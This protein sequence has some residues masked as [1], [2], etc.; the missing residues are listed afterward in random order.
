M[1]IDRYAV[2]LAAVFVLG[3][4]GCA[5]TAVVRPG[6]TDPT[7]PA[8]PEAPW[9]PMPGLSADGLPAAPEL[10]RPGDAP[11]DAGATDIRGYT[12]SMHPEVHSSSPGQCPKCGMRLIPVKP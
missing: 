9:A 12:C 10:A 11:P 7:N 8:A 5:S 1:R 4:A 3:V 2:P 6:A